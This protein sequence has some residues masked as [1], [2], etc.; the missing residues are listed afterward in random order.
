MRWLAPILLTMQVCCTAGLPDPEAPGAA[1]EVT[2][3][4]LC[5]DANGDPYHCPGGETLTWKLPIRVAAAGLPTPPIALEAAATAWNQWL[6][7]NAFVGATDPGQVDV[8]VV[9]GP[10]NAMFAGLTQVSMKTGRLTARVTMFGNYSARQDVI[11]HELGHVLG[12]GH[13]VG[14]PWSLMDGEPSWI[15]PSLAEADC[16]ALAAKYFLVNPP[17]LKPYERSP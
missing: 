8:W 6:G 3:W 9:A 2:F 1:P 7:V 4:R 16:R 12:L 17:C 13:D 11:A 10:Q 15:L 14:T 5:W